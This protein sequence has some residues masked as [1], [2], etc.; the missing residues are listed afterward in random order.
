MW[1]KRN[2]TEV[3]ERLKEKENMLSKIIERMLK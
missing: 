2:K 1:S 3:M